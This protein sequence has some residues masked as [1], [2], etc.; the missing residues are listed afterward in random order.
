MLLRK[1]G[2]R[3]IF[4]A[5]WCTKSC[6]WSFWAMGL[7]ILFRGLWHTAHFS[8]KNIRGIVII[9][10]THSNGTE[11]SQ[12]IFSGYQKGR[13]TVSP[14]FCHHRAQN[15]ITSASWHPR[16][17]HG[18]LDSQGLSVS[19][20]CVIVCPHWYLLQETHANK[21]EKTSLPWHCLCR[22]G[23]GFQWRAHFMVLQKV[24][25]LSPLGTSN[26]KKMG[27]VS[28]PPAAQ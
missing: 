25:T 11:A 24:S 3:Q 15:S 28:S 13:F 20:E 4:V 21:E 8:M 14:T 16:Q 10:I 18:S 19:W 2:C 27:D 1:R 22:Q 12:G 5:E 26:F 7:F 23:W 9:Q 17:W 6:F